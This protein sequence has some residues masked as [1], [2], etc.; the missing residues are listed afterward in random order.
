MPY[1]LSEHKYAHPDPIPAEHEQGFVYRYHVTFA[2]I[3]AALPTAAAAVQEEL[4]WDGAATCATFFVV[5]KEPAQEPG[6]WLWHAVFERPDCESDYHTCYMDDSPNDGSDAAAIQQLQNEIDEALMGA[7]G[8]RPVV[9]SP[10]GALARMEPL[11]Y[12]V[13]V[14]S[15]AAIPFEQPMVPFSVATY[16]LL[17]QKV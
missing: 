12:N 9:R 7:K 6:T 2:S 8:L 15:R 5:D 14:H 11:I 1:Q 10:A 16:E 13:T 4:F 3:I 17:L